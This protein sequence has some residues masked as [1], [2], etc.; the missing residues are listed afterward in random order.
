MNVIPTRSMRIRRSEP[1]DSRHSLHP[2]CVTRLVGEFQ[3]AN[4]ASHVRFSEPEKLCQPGMNQRTASGGSVSAAEA[5][6]PSQEWDSVWIWP[7][8][9][10]PEPP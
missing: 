4:N 7:M 3:L 10:R 1:Q 5:S 2:E 6:C 8:F 9:P